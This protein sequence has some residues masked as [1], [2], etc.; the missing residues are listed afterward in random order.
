MLVVGDI[1]DVDRSSHRGLG[2][3]KFSSNEEVIV[4]VN[5]YFA[6]FETA[7]FK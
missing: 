7:Y 1:Y 6:D 4:A 5:E 3:K 2:G